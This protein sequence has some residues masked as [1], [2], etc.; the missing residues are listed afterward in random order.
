M[1]HSVI[2][3]LLHDLGIQTAVGDALAFWLTLAEGSSAELDPYEIVIVP[4][5]RQSLGV[6]IETAIPREKTLYFDL[7][8]N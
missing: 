7:K 5:I 3:S 8:R 2:N 1:N 4:E 6:A